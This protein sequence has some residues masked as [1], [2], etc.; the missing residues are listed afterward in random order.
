MKGEAPQDLKLTS[1]EDLLDE[2]FARFD[3][4]VFKGRKIENPRSSSLDTWDFVGDWTTCAGLCADLVH[5]IH[6]DRDD[7]V[8]RLEEAP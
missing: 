7:A 5:E 1:T 4:A 6:K 3:H 2:L 8:E